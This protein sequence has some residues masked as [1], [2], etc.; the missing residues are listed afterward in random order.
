[1]HGYNYEEMAEILIPYLKENGYNYLELMPLNEYPAMS[2]GDIR[3]PA[4]SALHQD[5]G[6]R[7]S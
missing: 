4:F 2:P 1:M 7:T 6:Q 5:T 3:E